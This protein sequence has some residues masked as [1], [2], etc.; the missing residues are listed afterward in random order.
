MSD[1]KDN[2]IIAETIKKPMAELEELN[3]IVRKKKAEVRKAMFYAK[4]PELLKAKATA[5]AIVQEEAVKKFNESVK[6]EPE[7][8]E[9]VRPIKEPVREK[10][11]EAKVIEI[12]ND[13]PAAP[14]VIKP[15]TPQHLRVGLNAKWF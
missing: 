14:V 8:E 6:P 7:I 12:K 4:H 1:T 2:F 9:P 15:A 3:T 10:V 11:P 5:E 13:P